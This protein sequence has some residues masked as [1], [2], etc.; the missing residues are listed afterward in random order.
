MSK[1]TRRERS[2]I[3]KAKFREGRG[4]H[5]ELR[6]GETTHRYDRESE[7]GSPRLTRRDRVRIRAKQIRNEVRGA[8]GSLAVPSGW[9]DLNNGD[10]P[11]MFRVI[12][13]KVYASSI[14]G[15]A[16]WGPYSS[17]EAALAALRRGAK[18]SSGDFDD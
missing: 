17:Y 9:I 5:V 2:A 18:P 15:S 11:Y 7:E 10:D 3:N 13:G 14:G 8:G 6:G 12:K 1:L 4:G 16:E